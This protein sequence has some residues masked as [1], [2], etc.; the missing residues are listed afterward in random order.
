MAEAQPQPGTPSASLDRLAT[1]ERLGALIRR[2]ARFAWILA[3]IMVAIYLGYILLI[4][5]RPDILALPIG[6]GVTSLGIPLGIGVILAGIHLTGI[7]VRRANREF[8]RELDAIRR[9]HGL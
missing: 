7:Y 2:R 3:G 4:A 6:T 9:E 5:F 8:D 1:D